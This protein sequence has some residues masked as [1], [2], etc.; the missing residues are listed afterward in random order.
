MRRIFA[1]LWSFSRGN[2]HE[3][4]ISNLWLASFLSRHKKATEEELSGSYSDNIRQGFSLIRRTKPLRWF[5]DR[6]TL[7]LTHNEANLKMPPSIEWLSDDFTDEFMR[8]EIFRMT[9]ALD[10]I[11]QLLGP[12][13]NGSNDESAHGFPLSFLVSKA[14][15]SW[16]EPPTISCRYI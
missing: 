5:S 1:R 4:C 13:R 2:F 16:L 14:A 9:F 7:F 6:R 15:V 11:H 8:I 12:F 10:K 3:L